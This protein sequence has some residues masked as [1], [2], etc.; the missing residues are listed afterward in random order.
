MIFKNNNISRDTDAEHLAR[1]QMMAVGVTTY[2]VELD[3]TPAQILEYDTYATDIYDALN[4][5]HEESADVDESY[6]LVK[7]THDATLAKYRACQSVVK[8]EMESATP[9]TVEYLDERFDIEDDIPRGRKGFLK[10]AEFMVSAYDAILVEHPDVTLPATKF[11]ELRA[12]VIALDAAMKAIGRELA[13]QK[14]ATVSKNVLRKTTGEKGMRKC[15]HRAVAYWGDDDPRMLELGLVPKSSIWTPGQPEPEEPEEPPTPEGVPFP[16]PM[17]FFEVTYLGGVTNSVQ[18]SRVTGSDICV[19]ERKSD[20]EPE[21]VVVAE[22]PIDADEILPLHDNV[23]A[24]GIYYYRA[25]PYNAA[26]EPG[27]SSEDTVEVT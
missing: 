5:Q 12:L 9:E 26:M 13:E 17:A 11:E 7:N 10:M 25:T 8:G 16:G 6:V 24:P 1:A 18:C 2:G 3:F 4:S 20:G 22:F 14:S 21:W 23:P 27:I 19:I 15:F